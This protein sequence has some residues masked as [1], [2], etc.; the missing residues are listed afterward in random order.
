M[1]KIF[2]GQSPEHARAPKFHWCRHSLAGK[3]SSDSR[4]SL[5][6]CRYISGRGSI[7]P[8]HP[9]DVGFNSINFCCGAGTGEID[10]GAHKKWFFFC[11]K[12]DSV[13]DADSQF[14]KD[15]VRHP[16]LEEVIDK[17]FGPIIE[18][19]EQGGDFT[20]TCSSKA[21]HR[22]YFISEEHLLE[23]KIPFTTFIQKPG[24]CVV[25][26]PYSYHQVVNTGVMLNESVNFCPRPLLGDYRWRALALL[27]QEGLC[28]WCKKNRVL[29]LA[30]I[31]N[32]TRADNSACASH[33]VAKYIGLL[34]AGL[35][36]D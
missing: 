8:V 33:L 29:S 19:E 10:D 3:P 35:E 28:Y 14:A 6:A 4:C 34:Y 36:S 17:L 7:T 21:A 30:A 24:D 16:E 31:Q 26:G 20:N 1:A 18:Q 23:S 25:T 13:G 22:Q 2:E 9:E 11:G 27:E 15:K 32:L 5:H 12:P